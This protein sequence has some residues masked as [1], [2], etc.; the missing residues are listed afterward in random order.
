MTSFLTLLRRACAGWERCSSLSAGSP[1]LHDGGSLRADAN[2][3]PIHV[4]R[5]WFGF[6]QGQMLMSDSFPGQDRSKICLASKV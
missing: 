4:V 5:R 6:V 3:W 2:V 1:D